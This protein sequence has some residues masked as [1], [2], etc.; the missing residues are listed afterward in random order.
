MPPPL[1]TTHHDTRPQ[2]YNYDPLVK[3][4]CHSEPPPGENT[5]EATMKFYK[6]TLL[7]KSGCHPPPPLCQHPMRGWA[8]V[9][10]LARAGKTANHKCETCRVPTFMEI[11]RCRR[12]S[13]PCPNLT[14]T[15]P[16]PQRK[17]HICP[18]AGV[19]VFQK[20]QIHMTVTCGRRTFH[21]YQ[22][23]GA[24]VSQ[25]NILLRA[26]DLTFTLVQAGRGYDILLGFV[27][28]YGPQI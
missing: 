23:V 21:M 4:D 19:K 26:A 2:F 28:Y 12:D 8:C 27:F 11:K 7:V 14:T 5:T 16:P 18:P 6:Y 22:S 24:K 1:A 9:D 13:A 10:G 15:A 20:S 17:L 3:Y 25:I